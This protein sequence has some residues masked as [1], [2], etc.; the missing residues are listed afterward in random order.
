MSAGHIIGEPY[1]EHVFEAYA[2]VKLRSNVFKQCNGNNELVW[3]FPSCVS[4]M[5]NKSYKLTLTIKDP[6]SGDV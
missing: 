5:M 3:V 6:K 4:L 2:I 1:I